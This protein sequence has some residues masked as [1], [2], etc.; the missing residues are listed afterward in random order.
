MLNYIINK[1]MFV[2]KYNN[3]IINSINTINNCNNHCYNV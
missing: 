1:Y 2:L 3:S